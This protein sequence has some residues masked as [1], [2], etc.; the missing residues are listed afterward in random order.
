MNLLLTSG[1]YF[2]GYSKTIC[3][4]AALTLNKLCA[5][6]D[7]NA[8]DWPSRSQA[9]QTCLWLATVLNALKH[10]GIRNLWYSK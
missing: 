10:V 8:S 7:L 3:E 1:L 4:R 2:V 9:Q 5:D 6:S